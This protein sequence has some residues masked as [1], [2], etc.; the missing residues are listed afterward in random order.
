MA[1]PLSNDYYPAKHGAIMEIIFWFCVFWF[2]V[3]KI[4]GCFKANVSS[5]TSFIVTV[6]LIICVVSI[7][8]KPTPEEIAAN[9]EKHLAI[10]AANE[11]KR[12]AI[13]KA[14]LVKEQAE[15][16]QWQ[17]KKAER[18][19]V[20]EMNKTLDFLEKNPELAYEMIKMKAGVE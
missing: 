10:E 2:L 6:L 14:E 11:E 3:A 8:P 15:L 4:I 5:L 1:E 16:A 19:R 9:K 7:L 17:Q 18:A 13:E 12:L 20:E